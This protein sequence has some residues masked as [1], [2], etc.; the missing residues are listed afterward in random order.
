VEGVGLRLVGAQ[1]KA[2]QPG[3]SRDAGRRR[4]CSRDERKQGKQE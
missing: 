4:R 1:E 2:V 3:G